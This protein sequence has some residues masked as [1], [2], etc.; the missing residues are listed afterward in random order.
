M[1]SGAGLYFLGV[2][3]ARA[4]TFVDVTSSVYV[5]QSAAGG[6][7]NLASSGSKIKEEQTIHT[8][9]DGWAVLQFHEGS[10][11]VIS[12][13]TSLTIYQIDS[14]L[15]KKLQVVIFQED[16]KTTH[17]VKPFQSND[18]YY[19]V[20]SLSG[21]ASVHGTAFSVEVDDYGT[22]ICS[23]DD[24]EVAVKRL[25]SAVGRLP[26]QNLRIVFFSPIIAS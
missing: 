22:T 21:V 23:V 25:C 16:G 12:P 13:D 14:D 5:S 7:W 2:N 26:W 3:N 20:Q 18:S 6:E 17:F 19:L 9:S 24:G 8:D 15:H 10:R 4:A 11:L 1:L